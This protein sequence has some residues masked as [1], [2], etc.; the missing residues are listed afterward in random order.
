MEYP[1]AHAIKLAPLRR[2]RHNTSVN[3]WTQRVLRDWIDNKWGGV[4]AALW[5]LTTILSGGISG[6]ALGLLWATQGGLRKS[7]AIIV[8]LWT[9]CGFAG[10][11]IYVVVRRPS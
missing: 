2:S 4:P 1:L 8:V 9:L 11:W 7:D 3:I 6:A 10:G 5:D